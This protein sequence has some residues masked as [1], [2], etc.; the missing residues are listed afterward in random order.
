M[1]FIRARQHA[2]MNTEWHK[3]DRK[4]KGK[5]TAKKGDIH[6]ISLRA[7]RKQRMKDV[8]EG[9]ADPSVVQASHQQ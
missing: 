1:R 2:L 5:T 4:C 3:K 9:A 7:I 8:N 6:A